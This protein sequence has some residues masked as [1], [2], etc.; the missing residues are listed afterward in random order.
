MVRLPVLAGRPIRP[1][2]RPDGR[3]PPQ[4]GLRP[5]RA[6]SQSEAAVPKAPRRPA[7]D[8][9]ETRLPDEAR[10]CAFRRVNRQGVPRAPRGGPDGWS[11]VTGGRPAADGGATPDDRG[12]R[13][14][15]GGDRTSRVTLTPDGLHCNPPS[16]ALKSIFRQLRRNSLA[17]LLLLHCI[18]PLQSILRASASPSFVSLRQFHLRQIHARLPLVGGVIAHPEQPV[19]PDWAR[20]ARVAAAWQAQ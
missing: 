4:A 11:A 3:D 2:L 12:A 6:V 8:P 10:R 14:R 16:P 19:M 7:T 18:A 1:G 20:V 15:L 5:V 13:P 9:E 17:G